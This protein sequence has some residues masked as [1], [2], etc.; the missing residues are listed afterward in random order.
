MIQT[1]LITLVAASLIISVITLVFARKASVSKNSNDFN[2]IKYKIEHVLSEVKRIEASVKTEMITNRR[3]TGDNAQRIREEL[4]VS[5]RNFG[6]LITQT[7]ANANTTQKDN[8]FALLNKQSE[9]NSNTS[10][11]L[12]QMRE[13]LERKISDMQS[14]NERKL[15]EMR[16]R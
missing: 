13:T 10:L 11:K 12:D 9:Q 4:A 2:E 3:E 15:D 1:I 7:M 5:L 16:A 6:E 14:G 8:F